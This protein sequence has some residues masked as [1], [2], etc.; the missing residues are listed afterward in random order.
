MTAP[1][2][3]SAAPPTRTHSAAGV[4]A[5]ALRC[6]TIVLALSSGMLVGQGVSPPAGLQPGEP[7]RLLLVT[8]GSR[9]AASADIG[10]YDAF[11]TADANAVAGLAALNTR[12]RAVVSTPAVD[13]RDHTGTTGGGGVPIYR[14]DGIRVCDD[15]GSLWGT[16]TSLLAPANITSSGAVTSAAHVWTGTDGSGIGALHLGGPGTDATAG[17]P[18]ATSSSWISGHVGPQTEQHPLYGISDVLVVP[19]PDYP[20]G[21]KPGDRFR[22]LFVTDAVRDATSPDIA[23]YDAFVTADAQA[24]PAMQR[25]LTNWRAV[26]STDSIH[27]RDHIDMASPGGVPIFRP[28]GVRIADDYTRFWDSARVPLLAPI[29]VTPSGQVIGSARAWTGSNFRGYRVWP[30]GGVGVNVR[31]GDPT[32]TNYTWTQANDLPPSQAARVYGISD[33][34]TVP[35]ARHPAGLQPGDRYR[36]VFVTHATR[37]ATSSDIADY[38]AFVTADAQA[39]P[40]MRLLDTEWRAL[41]STPTASARAHTGTDSAGGLPIYL[42]NGTRVADDYDHLWG[43]RSLGPL[44]T[45]VGID[46]SGAPSS[47]TYVWTGTNDDGSAH[48]SPLG[49]PAGSSHTGRTDSADWAWI[50]TVDHPASLS[51][52]LFGISAVITVP[53]PERIGSGCGTATLSR[54]TLPR[55]GSSF[56]FSVSDLPSGDLAAVLLDFARPTAGTPQPTPLFAS[57][58]LAYLDIPRAMTFATTQ[59]T[60]ESFSIPVPNDPNL[61][62][63]PLTLQAA[64]LDLTTPQVTLTNAIAA[65]IRNP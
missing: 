62:G 36:V 2:R 1:S 12:W 56:T 19:Y 30:F 53:Y 46:S 23:D 54:D 60:N 38:D 39:F 41:A 43:T 3:N 63:L 20:D 44:Q 33:V 13:A 45:T 50:S 47:S 4:L 61:V 18:A 64:V 27:A 24:V 22:I 65:F 48:S 25:F 26:G 32:A 6:L 49:A 42:P 5:L 29:N 37:D 21:L 10:T 58:C 40:T 55:P 34:L 9:D 14:T 57:N 8:D 16:T 11:V 17:I 59:Q 7:Y 15:H 52:P 51:L 35:E 31:A 28:D